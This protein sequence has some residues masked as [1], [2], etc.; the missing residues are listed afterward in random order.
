MVTRSMHALKA[1]K[2]DKG[3]NVSI[4]TGFV[5]VSLL[6]LM[7]GGVDLVRYS[8][9]AAEL[10]A[11]NDSAI[12]AA[13]KLIGASTDEQKE[14]AYDYLD[15]NLAD[16]VSG[17][18]ITYREYLGPAD[19]VAENPAAGSAPTSCLD[20]DAEMDTFF[21]KLFNVPKLSV[22][23]SSQATIQLNPMEISF[24]FDTTGSMK[25]GNRWEDATE[26][27]ANMIGILQSAADSEGGDNFRVSLVAYSDRVTLPANLEAT[28]LD[29]GWPTSGSY[30][31]CVEPREETVGSD[32][33]VL[34]DK[35]PTALPFTPTQSGNYGRVYDS[36][37]PWYTPICPNVPMIPPTND[38]DFV[39]QG[40]DDLTAAGT[41]RFDVGAAWVWRTLSPQWKGLLGDVDYPKDY[42]DDDGEENIKV[43][44]LITDGNTVAYR[45]EVWDGY[46]GGSSYNQPFGWNKGSVEGFEH[47]V[48]VCDAMTAE[49]IHVHMVHVGGSPSAQYYNADF[50]SYA[51]DCASVE[52]Y[53]H[54]VDDV[55]DLIAAFQSIGE[56]TSRLRLTK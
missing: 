5:I 44:V 3:G 22:S 17:L 25:F 31:G 53:Y 8:T 18:T 27:L 32:L 1:L 13:S 29:P 51:Q 10:Q 49:G 56:Q 52:D 46:D 24:G 36:W 47:F 14:I 34:T 42:L 19:C 50:L 11:A 37:R 2:T 16:S 35:P 40:L 41:G 33:Y 4:L 7:G 39:Q 45:D 6:G 15:T 30:T 55:E 12:L 43:A 28:V 38:I 23:A 54:P 48:D 9:Y 26:A 21:M 20:I